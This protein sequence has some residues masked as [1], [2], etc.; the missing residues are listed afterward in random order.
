MESYSIILALAL[1]MLAYGIYVLVRARRTTRAAGS[2]W[3]SHESQTMRR[4][5]FHSALMA[6]V[7]LIAGCSFLIWVAVDLQ[8]S[9]LAEESP[10]PA[11][12][13]TPRAPEDPASS[14]G[15]P[16]A[17]LTVPT[18]PVPSLDPS[19][20]EPETPTLIPIPAIELTSQ[21]VVTNTGGG[22]LWLRDAPFGNG[23]V[24]LPEGAE[25]SVL[26]GLVEVNGMMWQI[27]A[28]DGREGW[29]AADYLI[30]R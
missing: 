29:A 23:L 9:T 14:T 4:T 28:A 15:T 30:Y 3:Y 7:L 17:T 8:R 22:G 2:A 13:E 19:G 12:S 18:T 6:V 26:G 25:V 27:V 16:T 10:T 5:A 1:G 24:L 11:V 21:A 20:G